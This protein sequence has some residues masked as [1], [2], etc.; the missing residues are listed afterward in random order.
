[1]S[2]ILR[3]FVD[4]IGRIANGPTVSLVVWFIGVSD[5]DLMLLKMSI[6]AKGELSTA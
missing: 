2:F 1:M 6:D 3:R 4:I 5:I